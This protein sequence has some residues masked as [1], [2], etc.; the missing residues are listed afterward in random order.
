M[1]D[2]A[3]VQLEMRS[4]VLT[5]RRAVEFVVVIGEQEGVVRV[6]A[7]RVPTPSG[8]EAGP[9]SGASKP[10]IYVGRVSNALLSA[11]SAAGS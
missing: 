6:P 9:R 11:S 3:G 5:L 1:G 4:A 10:T 7:T 8:G 2:F